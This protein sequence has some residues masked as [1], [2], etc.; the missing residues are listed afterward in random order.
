MTSLKRKSLDNKALDYENEIKRAR[1]TML[2][3]TV[4]VGTNALESSVSEI[5][6]SSDL[7]NIQ[8]PKQSLF[9]PLLLGLKKCDEDLPSSSWMC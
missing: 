7:V 1:N 6:V 3:T 2:E 5:S 8:Q 4:L 9:G